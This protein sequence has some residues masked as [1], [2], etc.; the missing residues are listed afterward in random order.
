MLFTARG[1][2]IIAAVLFPIVMLATLQF[3]FSEVAQVRDFIKPFDIVVEDFDQTPMSSML[4]NK[5]EEMSIFD[6]VEVVTEPNSRDYFSEQIVCVMTIPK[7]FFYD[8]FTME[9][10]AI[11]RLNGGMPDEAN[12]CESIILPILNVIKE[13]NKSF[14]AEYE[15][16]YGD[17]S[18]ITGQADWM[19]K[20]SNQLLQD[21]FDLIQDMNKRHYIEGTALQTLSMLSACVI[22][23][24][25]FLIP[26]YTL[27]TLPEDLNTGMLN[28]YRASKGSIFALIA[29]K[30]AS[31]LCIFIVVATPFCMVLFSSNALMALLSTLIIFI[32]CFSV[33]MPLALIIRDCSK[34]MLLSNVYLVASILLSGCIYPI[35]LY[36]QWA[37]SIAKLFAPYHLQHDY[38]RIVTD[39]P[40]SIN[41]TVFIA[42]VVGVAATALV[43][44][45][46]R[47]KHA[48]H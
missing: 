27:K 2:G 16:R 43:L 13:T 37:Q 21:I 20:M 44:L 39:A 14:C 38:Y 40:I 31:A 9:G 36:P 25:C 15:L 46:R 42:I 5:L 32:A 3:G 35:Q 33:L 48:K 11:I 23:L 34:Y 45:V 19:E 18:N 41:L 7:D 8:M 12:L 17:I 10:S 4:V 1:R 6:K 30:F 47:A 26:L 29:S 22:F 24:V 28:R